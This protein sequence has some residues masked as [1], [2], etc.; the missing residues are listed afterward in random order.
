MLFAE[1]LPR[2]RKGYFRQNRSWMCLPQLKN[3]FLYTN[4][5]PSIQYTHPSVYHFRNRMKK[6][7]GRHVAEKGTLFLCMCGGW[8]GV[9][10]GG[11][12]VCGGVWG[13]VCV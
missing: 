3:D 10:V 8:V 9:G 12:G 2:A 11:C 4:F 1:Q 5:S 6:A 13:C 7:L